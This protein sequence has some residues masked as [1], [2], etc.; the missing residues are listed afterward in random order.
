MQPENGNNSFDYK[1]GSNK[2]ATFRNFLSSFAKL[3]LKVQ[4]ESVTE[5][6]TYKYNVLFYFT[7]YYNRIPMKVY[8]YIDKVSF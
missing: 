8:L 3:I 5:S 2:I 4:N 7:K 6:N 1:T